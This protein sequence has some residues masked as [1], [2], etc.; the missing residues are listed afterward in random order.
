MDKQPT[1]ARQILALI[2]S[3][4]VLLALVQLV[5]LTLII[6]YAIKAYMFLDDHVMPVVMDIRSAIADVESALN[7][8]SKV[9]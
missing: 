4:P 5:M 9:F 1:R 7:K 6:V 8:V 2:Q 3:V